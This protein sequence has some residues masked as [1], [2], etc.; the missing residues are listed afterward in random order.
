V[1]VPLRSVQG[2]VLTLEISRDPRYD[3][4][5]IDEIELE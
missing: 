5:I 2:S 3:W 1:E 4:T